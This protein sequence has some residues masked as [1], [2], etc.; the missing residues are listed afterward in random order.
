MPSPACETTANL[1]GLGLDSRGLFCRDQLQ[2]ELLRSCL[3]SPFKAP[4]AMGGNI[5]LI[6]APTGLRKIDFGLKCLYW[7]YFSP[8]P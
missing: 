3:F 6:G 4:C 2:L 7:P 8:Y 1:T 5:C